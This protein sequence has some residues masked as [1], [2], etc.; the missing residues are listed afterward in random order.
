M[1]Q[2][3]TARHGGVV[4]ETLY[5]KLFF[6]PGYLLSDAGYDVWLGNFRGNRYSR[7]HLNATSNMNPDKDEH[8]WK[9]SIH[10]LG[11]YDLPAMMR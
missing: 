6:L 8:F 9:F 3:G 1:L 7:G 5:T 10:E 11:K 4:K 2:Q